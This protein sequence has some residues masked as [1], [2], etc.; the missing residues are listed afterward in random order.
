MDRSYGPSKSLVKRS[1]FIP[2]LREILKRV[3]PVVVLPLALLQPGVALAQGL[4][5]MAPLNPVSSSRSGL[6]FQPLRDPAPRRWVPAVSLDYASTIEFNQEPPADY[7]LDS[8]LMRLT[9]GVS[10]D[11]G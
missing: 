5:E 7:I 6:Y 9:L 11:L 3:T 10:R 8:E 1:R 4:P 2:V